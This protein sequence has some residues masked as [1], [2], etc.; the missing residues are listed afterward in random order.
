MLTHGIV[1]ISGGVSSIS[2]SRIP[3]VIAEQQGFEPRDSLHRRLI[4]NQL[5]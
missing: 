1:N 5:P 4:S 2:M 3:T